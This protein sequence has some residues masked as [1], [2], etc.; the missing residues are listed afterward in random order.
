M[1]ACCEGGGKGRYEHEFNPDSQRTIIDVPAEYQLT[2]EELKT[3]EDTW[4][5][6]E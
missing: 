6:V 2:E 4:A 5:K 1:G 3:Q